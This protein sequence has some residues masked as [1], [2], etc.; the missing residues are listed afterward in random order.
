MKRILSILL[1]G[2]LALSLAACSSTGSSSSSQVD[3]S[4]P[5]SSSASEVS[6]TVESSE[7]VSSEASSAAPSESSAE[8]EPTS[9][10]YFKENVAETEDLTI[11]ITD[12]KVI[13]VGE[14]GNEYGEAP[15]IAFWYDT[16]NKTGQ[17]GVTPLTAWMAVFTAVQDNDPNMV[18]TLDVGSTPDESALETQMAEIKEGGTVSC[19]IAYV[20]D[21]ETTPVTLTA[22]KGLLGEELGSQEYPIA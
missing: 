2:A 11:K 13:P 8:V 19:A 7:A 10:Y 21:D 9:E 17:E 14:T 4:T 20:L 16:T 15:V 1:C 5:E 12:Y 6:S 18:N 3:S 22:T